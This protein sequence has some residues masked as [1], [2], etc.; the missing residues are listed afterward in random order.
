MD[1][2]IRANIDDRDKD[3]NT[4]TDWFAAELLKEQRLAAEAREL[5]NQNK[6]A[7][8]QGQSVIDQN[9]VGKVKVEDVK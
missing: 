2:L 9:Y 4:W 7:A 5:E 3:G 1:R 6:R 8:E